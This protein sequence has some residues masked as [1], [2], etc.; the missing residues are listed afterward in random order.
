LQFREQFVLQLK[1]SLG[2]SS[3]CDDLNRLILDDDYINQG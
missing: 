3:F 1:P 2:V